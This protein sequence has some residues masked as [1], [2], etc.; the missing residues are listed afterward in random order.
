MRPD[1]SPCASKFV[2]WALGFVVLALL[3]AFLVVARS[4]LVPLVLGIIVASILSAWIERIRRTEIAGLSVPTGLASM[5]ALLILLLVSGVLYSIVAEQIALLMN[6]GP[7]FI[8]QMQLALLEIAALVSEDFAQ[9][10]AAAFQSYD[11]TPWFRTAAGSV[12]SLLVTVGLVLLYVGF[13]LA[14]RPWVASKVRHMFPDSERHARVQANIQ[15]IRHNVHHYLLLK[16]FISAVTGGVVYVVVLLFGLKFA[17]LLGLLTFFLNFIPSL[18]SIIATALPV[19][20]ALVQFDSITMVLMV[21]AVVGSVQFVL[22][23]IVDPM[24][25]GSSLQMSSLSI[26]V[27]LTFW[28]AIWGPVGMF[29]AVPLTAIV[30][31]VCAQVSVL[32]PV[33][34]LLSKSGEVSDVTRVED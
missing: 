15:A 19:L 21:L 29:L 5:V 1:L 6:E 26:V 18:G 9:A 2:S 17:I 16:T 7:L 13:L 28:S 3:L 14:E 11:L 20:V 32:K 10:L 33:A 4:F 22:G 31:I 27:S 23:N 12:G 25:T 30:M 34:V 8:A 24:V